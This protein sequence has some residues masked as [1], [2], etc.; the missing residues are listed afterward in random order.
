MKIDDRS[1]TPEDF[2]AFFRDDA[3]LNQLT[4]DDR[5][6]IFSQIMQGSSDFSKDMLDEVLSS[7]NV[8]NVGVINFG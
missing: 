7:Y 5:F 1:I 3:M 4:A 6:E 8:C 2:M